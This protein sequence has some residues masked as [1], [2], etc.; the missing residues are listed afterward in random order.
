MPDPLKSPP[1]QCVADEI[2]FDVFLRFVDSSLAGAAD[3]RTRLGPSPSKVLPPRSTGAIAR[4][5]PHVL[6]PDS[7]LVQHYS[8]VRLLFREMRHLLWTGLRR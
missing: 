2:E 5:Q 1:Q 8:H 7:T 4:A 6:S 3:E